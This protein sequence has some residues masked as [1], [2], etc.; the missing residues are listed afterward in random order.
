MSSPS[1]RFLL[2]SGCAVLVSA[3]GFRP[4]YA[5]TATGTTASDE[6]QSV[7]VGTMRDRSGQILRALLIERLNPRGVP[8]EPRYRLD[9]EIDESEDELGVTDTDDATRAN[10]TLV[11]RYELADVESGE[12]VNTGAVR[13]I[14]SFNILSDEY[15]TRTGRD[16]AR[17]RG[18][19]QTA[20]DLTLR[21]ALLLDR[22]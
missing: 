4:L 13:T 21:L 20:D 16:S 9:A 8:S 19:T 6:L 2:L 1:R 10:L 18:L 11:V 15:A 14:T 12:V 5:P 22:G 7:E 3:C 17:E